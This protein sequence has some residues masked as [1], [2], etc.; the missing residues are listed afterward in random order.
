MEISVHHDSSVAPILDLMEIGAAVTNVAGAEW[1]P[2][3]NSC[4]KVF[5]GKVPER[6]RTKR[7]SLK[8]KA[9]EGGNNS[10]YNEPV[11]SKIDPPS[12]ESEPAV[13]TAN[14]SEEEIFGR[15]GKL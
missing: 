14:S 1:A 2:S 7:R 13:S 5:S 10:S 6:D 11:E 4:S 15:E 8:V 9:G 3:S 12:T